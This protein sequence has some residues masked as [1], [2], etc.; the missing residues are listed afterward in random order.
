LDVTTGVE[1]EPAGIGVD[2]GSV[3]DSIG[4]WDIAAPTLHIGCHRSDAHEVGRHTE[5]LHDLHINYETVAE[6]GV[7]GSVT[8]CMTPNT[9]KKPA[10]MSSI[11]TKSPFLP[12]PTD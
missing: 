3:F 5:D 2:G 6:K 8:P 12:P 9:W 11:S 10:A 7:E 4:A 1:V